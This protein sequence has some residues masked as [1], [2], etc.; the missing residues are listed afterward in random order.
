MSEK[1]HTVAIGAFI[2]GALLIAV[3]AIV[4]ISGSGFGQ[5]QRKVVMV[6]NGSVKGLT[7]GAPV[8][9]RGVQ[10]GQVT[11]IELILDADTLEV[12]MLVEAV[13]KSEN[14]RRRGRVNEE[15]IE[16][17]ISQGMRAQLNTQSLLTGLL[18]IQFDFHPETSLDLVDVESPYL[19][20]PTIPTDLER[21]TREVEQIDI[22]R[23]AR[24]LEST[25]SGLNQFVLAENFQALPTELQKALD[26]VTALS[27]DLRAQ[28]A[29]SGPRLDRV[30]DEAGTTLESANGEIPEIT[31]ALRESLTGLDA[32]TAA[33]EGAMAGLEGTVAADST[34][35]YQLN[36]A[37]KEVALAGRALQALAKTL[38]RQPEALLRGK[39]GERP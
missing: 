21:I 17:L 5:D 18:Y 3:I 23:I 25:L 38:E 19:Q 2:V 4:I 15:L 9:L 29:S 13:L 10:I 1:P 7:L 36:R 6:F 16:E 33:F 27:E 12:I 22:A 32:A 34:T 11:N 8:A 26:S 24:D 14:I 31:A 30:L 28:L 35:V 37:L 20:I 39:N